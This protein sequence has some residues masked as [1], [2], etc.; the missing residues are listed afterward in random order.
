MSKAF[1][2]DNCDDY[3]DGEP[4]E[5]LYRK[6]VIDRQ[7]VDYIKVLDLCEECTKNVIDND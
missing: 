1:Y 6:D 5:S 7:G 4:T 3:F 2:C